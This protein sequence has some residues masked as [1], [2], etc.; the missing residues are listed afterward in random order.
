[1]SWNRIIRLIGTTVFS[2]FFLSPSHA[3]LVAT[4]QAS[5]GEPSGGVNK[6]VFSGTM[7]AETFDSAGGTFSYTGGSVGAVGS[8]YT[9][10]MQI[11]LNPDTGGG[12]AAVSDVTLSA[13]QLGSGD[14]GT[15][16]FTFGPG[17]S[18]GGTLGGAP[19]PV[20]SVLGTSA[21]FTFTGGISE[22]ATS[23]A[24][25][26]T[27]PYLDLSATGT[28]LFPLGDAVTFSATT[29]VASS[30]NSTLH[31]TTPVPVPAAVWLF[32]SGLLGLGGAAVRRRKQSVQ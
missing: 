10:V 7:Y 12:L 25:Y 8:G 24:F 4:G 31:L 19:S 2:G 17:P 1:M 29:T 15:P 9:T 18:G 3:A 5:F 13:Y 16:A 22:G 27:H 30:V 21:R 14:Y 26:F 32:G 6:P 23:A 20:F 28:S 11:V